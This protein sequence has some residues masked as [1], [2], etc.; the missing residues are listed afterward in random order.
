MRKKR[1]LSPSE[2]A[3]G[4]DDSNDS[5]SSRHAAPPPQPPAAGDDEPTELKLALLSSLSPVLDQE[6]LLDV[7]LAHDGDVAA[8]SAAL[9]SSSAARPLRKP[10]GGVIGA[11]T[12][13]R[14]FAAT[15]PAPAA[16][17]T[18]ATAVAGRSPKKSRLLTRKGATVHLFDPAD[19]ALHTPCT[20]VLDFLPARLADELLRELVA[21]SASFE[22]ITFKLFDAV[23]SS[24]HTSALYVADER[25][26]DAQ[27]EEY[28]YNG[29]ALTDV[30]PLTP[31]LREV[32]PLVQDAVNEAVEERVRLVYP[33]RRKLRHMPKPGTWR[34]NAAFV[35]CYNGGQESVGWHSDQLTY[36][37]PRAIIGSLSLG[38]ARE[39][40]VRRVLT[41]P[42]RD[43]SGEAVVA[44]WRDTP[45]DGVGAGGYGAGED[46]PTKDGA[47]NQ[48][49]EAELTRLP[50]TDDDADDADAPG[51]V[52]GQIAIHLPHNSLLVMHAEMQEEWKHSVSPA[53]AIDPHPVSGPRR[54]NV[55][56]RDYRANMH[57][58]RTP[59]CGC[60]VPCVL[61]VVQKEAKAARP[62]LG[63]YFWMCHGGN[64]P[65]AVN[66]GF[67]K[68][69]AFDEDGNPVWDRKEAEGHRLKKT[70][71]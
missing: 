23:V 18:S 45:G 2:A 17:S 58:S 41:M 10:G 39:F 52:H 66:C 26:A 70:G 32:R 59:R 21:E 12:S 54:I 67:F 44:G 20:L 69:A 25:E 4:R 14:Q 60:D 27:R 71:D 37:G 31:L 56:Y 19:V 46:G 65:G 57:P 16:S 11:Q 49:K 40:R 62:N 68:W 3:R 48:N 42:R 15:L 28:V 38:V 5:P 63:R 43:E 30:R 33:G 53:A 29:S 24:P 7:L 55:T 1:P 8:A 13:L 22:K 9:K 36:L 51:D 6:T 61:R 47:Q 50:A 35:N 64:R 34:P